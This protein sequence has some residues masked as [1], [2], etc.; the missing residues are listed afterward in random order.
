LRY[1]NQALPIAQ[2]VG[3][4][5]GE[6]VTLNNIGEVYRR[7]GQ[8]QEALTYF[9]QALPIRQEVG[10]RSG[11]ATTL[12]NIGG[13]YNGIGQP[14]KAITHLEQSVQIYLQMRQGFVRENRPEFLQQE[15]GT[16]IALT[17]LLIQ[18]QQPDQ[19]FEWINRFTAADLADYN[20]LLGARFVDPA[21]QQAVDQ[22]NQNNQQLQ[23]LQQALQTQ[24]SEPLSR[25]MRAKEA[26]VS[27][28]AEA[29]ARQYPEA[30]ELFETTPE[31]LAQLRAAIPQGSLV[32]QPVLL[33]G[34]NN[35][36]DTIA[37]FILSK[38]QPVMVKQ[39]PLDSPAFDA[40]VDQYRQQVQERRNPGFAASQ[41]Q[42]Y[43]L[44]IRPIE[45]E[46]AAAAPTQLS[47][48]LTG[49]LR[50][51]PFETL[52]NTQTGQHLIEQYPV[53]YLTRLSTRSPRLAAQS[54]STTSSS[55]SV[56]ALGNPVPTPPQNLDGAEA[57]AKAIAQIVPGSQTFLEAQ[58]TLDAFK[59]QAPRF[60]FLHL[61]T[62]GCFD[63][64]GC[65]GI[66]MQTN[67]LLLA[68][69]QFNIA[70]AALLGL[71]NTQLIV[72]SACQTAQ[73]ADANGEEISG[74]AYLFERAGARAVIASLWSA[75]DAPTQEI[76]VQFYQ[77]LQQGM[78]KTEALRQAKLSYLRDHP[79]THP[80][81]WSPLVLIGNVD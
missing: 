58:A 3:D 57:E 50:Y 52:Y 18:Q 47:F 37:F 25:Q 65:P 24:F 73:Q 27:Q 26:E 11:E 28:Q 68:D 9:N 53:N 22:W 40:L 54:N 81:F 66:N 80:F 12:S 33:T 56:F 79:E 10:D 35:V 70:D 67:T 15:R 6:A 16:V 30:A 4:R 39:V 46:I 77:N 7:I 42:L 69:Q 21:T 20:R 55:R 29:I 44:L 75:A 61:A 2:E 32:V 14:Q 78:S 13:V 76:M 34:V 8:P 72:L 71:T 38:D 64:E 1:Y 31:D 49:K 17:D 62:H 36:P 51:I 41:E 74:L 23:T 48:I 60:P 5:S 45:A 59:T 43:D 19:A 63:P